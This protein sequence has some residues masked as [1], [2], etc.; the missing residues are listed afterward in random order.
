MR[1]LQRRYYCSN[2]LVMVSVQ[3]T[4]LFNLT[5]LS[6]LTNR[7]EQVYLTAIMSISSDIIS[8]FISGVLI[9]KFGVRISLFLTYL[10]A[11]IGGV[12]LL[13]YGLD[14]TDSIA[15]PIFFLICRFG[16]GGAVLI[17][18]AANSRIFDIEQASTAF[19]LSA[20]FGRLMLSAA[21]VVSTVAQP[22]PTL[23]FTGT[24]L[25]FSAISFLLKIHPEAETYSRN[26]KA[27]GG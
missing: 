19:G 25:A 1:D 2:F 26:R 4:S 7:F 15:F 17:V 11:G 22:V 23:I 27:N 10:I 3:T 9:E 5:L 21:P 8:I 16:V 18:V 14:H 6:Y 20:F 24:C 12:L 13:T